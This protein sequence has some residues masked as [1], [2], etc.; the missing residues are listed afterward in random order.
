MGE[1]AAQ[2][3]LDQTWRLLGIIGR[4]AMGIVYEG[5][6]V[7][8][9]RPVAVKMMRRELVENVEC[10]AR[11][12]REALAAGRIGSPHIIEVLAAGGDAR[13]PYIVMELLEGRS[14]E[15]LL[16]AETV[17]APDRAARLFGQV[18]DGLG[19]AHAAG[20]IHRDMKP[21]NVF[22]LAHGPTPDFVKLLDFGVA[23]VLE[24]PGASRLTAQGGMM[25]TVPYLAPE[26]V[27]GLSQDTD[28]RV[29][30]WATGVMLFRALTGRFPHTAPSQVEILTAIVT[31][32][33][34]PPS[35]LRT[36]LPSGLDSLMHRAL[37]RNPQKRFATAAEFGAALAPFAAAAG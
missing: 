17:L 3:V 8:D 36:G 37:H 26:L 16:K 23:K 15:E 21:E 35:T 12:E 1:P 2:P 33:A 10:R 24:G 7:A 27:A 30:L 34:P 20:I 4:G 29:D 25:G 32:N 6:R 9:D 13:S 11:F 19:A 22:L 14:L 5:R 31:Q 18:L 28:H